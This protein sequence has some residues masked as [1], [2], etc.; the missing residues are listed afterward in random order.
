MVCGQGMLFSR[1][2][3]YGFKCGRLQGSRDGVGGGRGCRILHIMARPGPAR[4]YGNP[5][6]ILKRSEGWSGRRGG[7]VARLGRGGSRSR[8]RMWDRGCGHVSRRIR[9]VVWVGYGSC[10]CP[11][12]SIIA[13]D[14]A[15]C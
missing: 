4:A 9:L 13:R 11:T 2:S 5:L 3:W 14:T 7:R 15:L 10:R 8:C 6:Q 1:V 12:Y